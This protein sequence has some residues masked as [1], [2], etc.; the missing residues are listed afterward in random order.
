M[1]GNRNRGQ[2]SSWTVT[3]AEEEKE[4]GE[5]EEDHFMDIHQFIVIRTN[6][7][8]CIVILY[9]IGTSVLIRRTVWKIVR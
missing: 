7:R 6:K 2:G 3:P 1:E 4:E 5:E 8:A 9:G